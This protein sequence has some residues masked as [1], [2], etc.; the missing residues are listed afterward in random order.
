MYYGRGAELKA[1]AH[2]HGAAVS[3]KAA[4]HWYGAAA[5]YG[6]TACVVLAPPR[7]WECAAEDEESTSGAGGIYTAV[8]SLSRGT[9]DQ[10]YP[11]QTS[12]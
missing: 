8:E 2:W 11:R 10:R 4:A 7:P 12:P 5:T 9:A 1:A 3:L 6:A